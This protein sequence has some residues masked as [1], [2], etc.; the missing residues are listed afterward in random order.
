SIRALTST[1]RIHHSFF[2]LR[3]AGVLGMVLSKIPKSLST[4]RRYPSI[5]SPR[6]RRDIRGVIEQAI[7]LLQFVEI[8]GHFQRGT[9]KIFGVSSGAECLDL[10][11][12]DH[13]HVI[14]PETGLRSQAWR[15]GLWG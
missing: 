14:D 5:A 4:A 9:V 8:C 11:D 15:H 13:V 12:R 6:E 3:K 1:Q 7:G 10:Q 2:T